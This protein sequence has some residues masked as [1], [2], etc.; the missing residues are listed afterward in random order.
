MNAV[1]SQISCPVCAGS[2]KS[3][4]RVVGLAVI[5]CD[6]V[7]GPVGTTLTFPAAGVVVTRGGLYVD[8]MPEKP[9]TA[10]ELKS[11]IA[12]LEAKAKPPEPSEDVAALQ[13]KL[14]ALK[15]KEAQS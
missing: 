2:H 8:S 9:K 3:L 10:A 12:A 11:E 13:A 1:E 4:A 14:D 6:S 5:A 15:A 7:K